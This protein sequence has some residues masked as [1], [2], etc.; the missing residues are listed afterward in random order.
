MARFCVRVG[1]VRASLTSS[2]SSPGEIRTLSATAP[3]TR[4]ARGGT[5]LGIV[6][7]WRGSTV[8]RVEV[9]PVRRAHPLQDRRPIVP[10]LARALRRPRRHDRP[11]LPPRQQELQ[12]LLRRQRPLNHPIRPPHAPT[13]PAGAH[14]TKDRSGPAPT[15]KVRRA[16]SPRPGIPDG[17]GR[18]L[19]PPR[20]R[21]AGA[22]R[23]RPHG[24]PECG[25]SALT[26][27]VTRAP[28]RRPRAG[29]RRCWQAGG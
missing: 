2:P 11:G 14:L 22:P 20:A 29:P 8:H 28:S 4:A 10:Q 6:E 16:R 26:T 18:A 1:E 12:P 19:G 23:P 7:G 24:L 25:R 9:S 15:S 27:A 17:P 3:Q 5:G 13:E 21:I